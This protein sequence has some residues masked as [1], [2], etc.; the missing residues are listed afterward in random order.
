MATFTDKHEWTTH[1]DA[2]ARVTEFVASVVNRNAY[3]ATL[4]ARLL[5]ETGTR[6][7]DWVDRIGCSNPADFEAVGFSEAKIG[8]ETVWQHPKAMLPTVFE[9]TRDTL[10]IHVDS[11]AKFLLANGFDSRTEI[12]GEPRDDVRRACVSI[13]G[14]CEFHVVE[15]HGSLAWNPG[16]TGSRQSINRH[17]E[18]ML[19]RQRDFD[20]DR[21][22]FEHAQELFKAAANDVGTNRACE[23]FF[24]GERSYW[25]SRNRAARIQKMR[26]DKLGLGWANQDHHT[27]RSGRAAFPQLIETLELMGFQCRERFYAGA[28][29]GWGAQVLEQVDC[30]IVIFADVDLSHEEIAGDFAHS[31]LPPQEKPGTVGLWCALHGEAFLQAGMHHLECQFDFDASREQLA[32]DG[33]ETMSPFT[34][35]DHLRQAFTV[36]ERWQVPEPR[37]AKAIVDGFITEEEANRFR[38][39]GVIGSHLEILE[40][41]DGYK[42]FNKTGISD[43]ILET[44]PKTAK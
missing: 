32:A 3:V 30:R 11:V 7:I 23:M 16:P 22:G 36:G 33:V 8:A 10:A 17:T 5:T 18:A 44:N 1:A 14:D 39:D 38:T 43:I 26:Q 24:A 12:V 42:G 41:N 37:L 2:F 40:R 28:D 20:T 13:E 25:Q 35:F 27:Y 9:T 6:L 29:A 4:Q 21:E 31:E 19:L 34:D 15:R